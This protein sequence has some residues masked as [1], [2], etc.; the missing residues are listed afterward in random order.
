M[1]C[2]KGCWKWEFI[3]KEHLTINGIKIVREWWGCKTCGDQV[4]SD[5]EE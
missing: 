1:S 5:T 2:E 4:Y 3:G